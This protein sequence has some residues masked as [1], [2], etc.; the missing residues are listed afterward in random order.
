MEGEGP[1]FAAISAGAWGAFRRNRLAMF[2]LGVVV[3]LYLSM[4]LAPLLAPFEAEFRTAYQ[5]SGDMSGRLAAPSLLHIMGTDQYSQDVLSRIL[6]G[7]RISLTIGLVA[8][9]ISVSLGAFLGAVAGFTGGWVDA[10]IMRVVD[11][12]MAI[13]R[14]VVLIAIVA[15]FQP[16]IFVVIVALAFTQ[17]PFTTRLMRGEILALKEREFHEAA[18]ALGFSRGRILFR[19]LLPNA[20]GP[21]I[22]V[23]TLGVGNAIVL[24]A[25]LSFL[26]L[27]VP[28]GT[29]SWGS[30]VEAGRGVLLDGVWWVSTFPGLAI[31]LA[32]LAF[33]LVGDGLRDAL[34]PRQRE[35][36]RQ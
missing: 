27:G 12:V 9:G 10:A 16:N 17:W 31:V 35:G 3:I 7:A 4:L 8:V 25:G 18:R 32:V 21:L 23:A 26:G 6:Y 29:P 22:V 15:L 30:M 24:E 36:A 5:A 14:L 13:P 33:N 34:D 28:A 19:H 1:A 20:V 11:M 2:G